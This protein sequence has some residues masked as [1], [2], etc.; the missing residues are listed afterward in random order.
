MTMH[1]EGW[2]G[3]Y[4]PVKK[5]EGATPKGQK[6]MPVT[7]KTTEPSKPMATTAPATIKPLKFVRKG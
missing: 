5:D 7:P 6:L 4:G 2:W 3:D 1:C